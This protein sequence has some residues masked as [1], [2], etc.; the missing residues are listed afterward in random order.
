[1]KC[2]LIIHIPKSYSQ[3]FVYG[4]VIFFF[5]KL[6][7]F[8]FYQFIPNKVLAVNI[9][10]HFDSASDNRKEKRTIH[11]HVGARD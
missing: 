9:T 4:R 3:L 11:P 2:D 8:R 5:F 10:K 7:L 6:I 1:M